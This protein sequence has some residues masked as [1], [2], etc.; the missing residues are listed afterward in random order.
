MTDLEDILLEHLLLSTQLL[1]RALRYVDLGG[2]REPIKDQITA[3]AD[4]LE[5]YYDD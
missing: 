1:E 4:L 3:N 2:L 5:S